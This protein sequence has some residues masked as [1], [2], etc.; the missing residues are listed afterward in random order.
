MTECYRPKVVHTQGGETLHRLYVPILS[1]SGSVRFGPVSQVAIMAQETC[2]EARERPAQLASECQ[3]I[4][5]ECNK[6]VVLRCANGDRH[7]FYPQPEGLYER[8][9]ERRIDHY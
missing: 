6:P 4:A 7:T 2:H 5:N 8:Y 1:A 3:E 9:F